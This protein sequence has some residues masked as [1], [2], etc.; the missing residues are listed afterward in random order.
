MWHYLDLICS[1]HIVTIKIGLSCSK[2]SRL[3]KWHFLDLVC[4][5]H[6]VTNIIGEGRT[7]PVLFCAVDLQTISQYGA[8]VF[9]T[10]YVQK[11]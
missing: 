5:V 1:V 11:I 8:S 7:F 6:L 4:S 3:K 10:Y 2:K 9:W